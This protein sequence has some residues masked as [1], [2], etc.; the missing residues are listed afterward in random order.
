MAIGTTAVW[1]IWPGAS[2]THGSDTN[3]GGFDTGIAS[4]GTDYSQQATAQI[5][6]TDAVTNNTTTVTSATAN[7]S[8]AHIGNAVYLSGTGTT[9]GR[10]FVTGV[11]NATTITVDRA[12]GST[13]GTGV[14]LNLGG[15]WR[16][17]GRRSARRAGSAGTCSG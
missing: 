16:R 17:W 9:T 4:Y 5:A 11:T 12:T 6:V 15:R 2:G 1:E 13:G 10:Y 14:T 7:F 3:G 8:A